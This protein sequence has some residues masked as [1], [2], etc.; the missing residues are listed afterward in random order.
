MSECKERKDGNDDYGQLDD[1]ADITR[2]VG[3]NS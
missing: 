1:V 3:S 2:R